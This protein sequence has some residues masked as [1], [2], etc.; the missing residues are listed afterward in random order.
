LKIYLAG[1]GGMGLEYAEKWR[2]E[3]EREFFNY[4]NTC[5][6]PFR[7]GKLRR[8]YDGGSYQGDKT[9]GANEIVISDLR[10]IQRCDVLLAE[11]R[12]DTYN[13]IG[14]SSEIFYARSI[15]KPVVIWTTEK[16]VNHPWLVHASVKIFTTDNLKEVCEY[17]NLHWGD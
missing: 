7:N 16:Y 5:I 2:S 9:L 13:Y 6:N 8:A 1:G 4:D 17:I 14:T 11:M 10:D 15:G 12:S 3:A